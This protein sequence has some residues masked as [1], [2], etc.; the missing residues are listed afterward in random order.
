MAPS[1]TSRW[2][3]EQTFQDL[4]S[5]VHTL[6]H[7]GQAPQCPQG[8]WSAPSQCKLVTC[9]YKLSKLTKQYSEDQRMSMHVNCISKQK[10]IY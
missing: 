8:R 7:R 6:I 1:P 2:T 3:A 4:P 10:V 9:V 5:V